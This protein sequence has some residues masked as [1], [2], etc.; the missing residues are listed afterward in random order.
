MNNNHTDMLSSM[1]LTRTFL[2]WTSF[3]WPWG[4]RPSSGGR[5]ERCC[6]WRGGERE[7]SCCRGAG[8]GR[9]GSDGRRAAE[10]T[11]VHL[12]SRVNTG[13]SCS[14]SLRSQSSS[15]LVWRW[16][17]LFSCLR[18]KNNNILFWWSFAAFHYI[19]Y[20]QIKINIS[21]FRHSESTFLL[22]WRWSC[23]AAARI[24]TLSRPLSFVL[25]A[26]YRRAPSLLCQLDRIL[27]VNWRFGAE[28]SDWMTIAYNLLWM[29]REMYWVHVLAMCI[30][31]EARLVL[32]KINE[33]QEEEEEHIKLTSR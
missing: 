30:V 12:T 2:A 33:V 19:I 31:M 26:A 27:I 3:L 5:A 21:L 22:S 7:I 18:G 15:R 10:A 23:G 11:A 9:R 17:C 6:C 1:I 32:H 8:R 4:G 16:W 28:D 24:L 13:C 14:P 25:L 29:Q 20:W